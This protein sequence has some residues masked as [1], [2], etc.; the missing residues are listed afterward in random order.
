MWYL[1]QFP[2]CPFSRKV[3]LLLSEKGVGYELVRENPWEHREEFQTLNPALRTPVLTN[4]ERG[5]VLVDSR[6]I[7]EYFEE[8]VDKAPMINGTAANG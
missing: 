5:L 1:Y 8:T 2:I 3:R 7:A 6:A 4:P